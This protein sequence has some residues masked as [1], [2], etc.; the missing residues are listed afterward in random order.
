LEELKA[1]LQE[2]KA[3][4]TTISL[5]NL[6]N[7]GWK[8]SKHRYAGCMIMMLGD[9]RMLYEPN[10][11]RITLMYKVPKIKDPTEVLGIGAYR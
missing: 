11:K 9:E 8:D 3:S 10:S 7:I 6:V 5:D 4:P 2:Q 1:K